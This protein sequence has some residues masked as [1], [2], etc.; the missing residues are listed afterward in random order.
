M[1]ESQDIAD[2]LMVKDGDIWKKMK[3]SS[4]KGLY[5]RW[6]APLSKWKEYERRVKQ[7]LLSSGYSKTKKISAK[8]LRI[9][10]DQNYASLIQAIDFL[11][12]GKGKFGLSKKDFFKRMP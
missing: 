7:M 5:P 1:K 2:E 3:L 8:I 12:F 9:L 10:E 4:A 11:G 6:G